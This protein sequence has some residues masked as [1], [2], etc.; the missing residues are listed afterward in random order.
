MKILAWDTETARF[1][2]G[3]MAPELV[4]V[5]YQMP[6]SEPELVHHTDAESL[7]KSWLKDKSLLLV[8]QHVVYDLAVV[9]AKFPGVIPHVYQAYE[10]DRIADTKLRQQLIDIGHGVYRGEYD[11]KGEWREY[12]YSLDDLL[13]RH[14]KR[15]LNKDSWRLSYG[16]FQ[17]VPLDRWP[18]RARELQERARDA[19]LRLPLTDSQKKELGDV[20]NA[21]PDEITIYPKEDARATL[22]VFLAQEPYA[23]GYL[24]DQFR[25]ARKAW[26]LHLLH[27]WGLRTRMEGVEA[28]RQI[29]EEAYDELQKRLVETG[30][31]RENG[32]RDTKVAKALMVSVCR[33]KGLPIRRTAAHFSKDK[34][35]ELGDQCD[36]HICL[37]AD[38]CSECDDE[39]LKEYGELSVLKAVVSK[40]VPMLAA[41]TIYPVHSKF[42]LAETGRT[43][44]SSP[45]IQNLR[46]LVGIRECFVPREGKVFIDADYP[47]LEL[48]TLAQCCLKLVGHSRLAEVL[49]AGLD[50]HTAMAADILGISYDEAIKN[51][52]REDVDNARQ[53][54]KVANFG[55]PGGLGAEKLVLFA[56]KT[57]GVI[58]TID[59]AKELKAQWLARWP[60]MK[61]YFAYINR[62]D[63]GVGNYSLRHLFTDRLRGGATYTAACNSHFQG[64]GADA[65]ARAGWLI[66]KACYMDTRSPLFGSR[67]VNYIHDQF[68]AETDD[69]EHAH[70]AAME[71]RK[72]M[73]VGANEYLPDVPFKEE[74]ID[75][76][77]MRYWSK[78][79]KAVKGADGRL[80]PWAG[81]V[82]A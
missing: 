30:L 12:G 2:P 7:L 72:L 39:V 44:S 69:N 68:H 32:T 27:L 3:V 9:C 48:R 67:L 57:Y 34:P 61:D 58:L 36:S 82:A 6:G 76:L 52:S 54:S 77:L 1:R 15:R 73:V 21:N 63:D 8:G 55:L 33:E 42:D 13:H 16:E 62:L 60:E 24:K 51:K 11:Q 25:Q 80:I 45:N 19:Y 14:F 74:E 70:E 66:S 78:K 75:V 79:A 64:L 37:D 23:D 46:R 22:D 47:Q 65:T 38:A 56:R 5:S 50:P 28:F 81:G 40:D 59:R 43:T 35:C 31:V 10:D 26:W 53:T 41:G 18:E 29:Q 71:L 17:D 49:N 20:I 4:C